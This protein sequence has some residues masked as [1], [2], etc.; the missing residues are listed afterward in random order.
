MVQEGKAMKNCLRHG[1]GADN[2]ESGK[3]V[4]FSVVAESE[5]LR[6]RG[7]E[8]GRATLEI[9]RSK[10]VREGEEAWYLIQAYS[11]SNHRLGNTLRQVI[12]QSTEE[13]N[14]QWDVL[15]ELMTDEMMD[16]MGVRNE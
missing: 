5:E 15:L 12:S 2:A 14:K 1:Y 4:F 6:G 9:A 7:N 11:F 16:G 10:H 8:N 3:R 13:I